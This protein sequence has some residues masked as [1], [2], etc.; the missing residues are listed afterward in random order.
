MKTDVPF[1]VWAF[2]C[3]S[4]K[5]SYFITIPGWHEYAGNCFP[6]QKT[7]QGTYNCT[8]HG[9]PEGCLAVWEEREYATIVSL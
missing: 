4:C 7:C 2:E 1:R 3:S 6:C 8:V 9:A 5:D